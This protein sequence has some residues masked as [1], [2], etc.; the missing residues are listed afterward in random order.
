MAGILRGAHLTGSNLQP[1]WILPEQLH[2]PGSLGPKS[3]LDQTVMGSGRGW[4][5]NSGYQSR[6]AQRLWIRLVERAIC[7][8]YSTALSSMLQDSVTP[9]CA[10]PAAPRDGAPKYKKQRWARVSPGTQTPVYFIC[11]NVKRKRQRDQWRQSR[12][13]AHKPVMCPSEELP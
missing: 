9:V 11:T 1:T 3:G 7:P 8:S 12:Q 10:G 13:W 5:E 2:L 4:V 6:S